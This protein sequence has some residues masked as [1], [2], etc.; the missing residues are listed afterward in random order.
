MLPIL[1]TQ[2]DPVL[3]RLQALWAAQLNPLLAQPLAGS[4]LLAN[5][6]LAAGSNTVNHNLGRALQGWLPVRFQGG[7]AQL[8]DLQSTNPLPDRTL[9]LVASAPVTVSLLV[10]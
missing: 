5:V 10:F 8:Y 2:D 3:N 1:T 4:V 6:V 7:W 9:T